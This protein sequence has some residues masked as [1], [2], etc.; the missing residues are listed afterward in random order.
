MEGTADKGSQG[1][2][3]PVLGAA[4]VLCGALGVWLLAVLADRALRDDLLGQALLVAG[5]VDVGHIRALAGT[6]ADLDSPG[7][8][9]LKEQ[10]AAVR[11]AKPGCRFAYLMARRA[12]GTVVFL[13]DSEPAGSEDE[14]PAGRI[15]WDMP[16]DYLRA[17]DGRRP[18]VAGPVPDRW[19]SWVTALVPLAD[20]ASGEV[21]AVLGMD[22][23]ARDWTWGVAAR[24]ALPT[25]MLLVL[26]GLVF[27]M[28]RR[29]DAAILA[30][31]ESLRKSEERFRLLAQNM[32]GVVY[33]RRDDGRGAM[34]YVNDAVE[35]LTGHPARDFLSGRV[36]L[37]SLRHPADRA[38]IRS[39]ATATL[40][41]GV[42]FRHSYRIAHR[43][44]SWRWIEE[45]AV[46]VRQPDG[47]AL[48][49]GHLLDI[50]DRMRAEEG[51]RRSEELLRDI[52][53]STL[54]GYWE[55][56]F[57]AGTAY[58]SPA[59]KRMFGYGESEIPETLD[60]WEGIVFEDDLPGDHE[61][62]D[63]HVE[64]R[65]GIPYYNE[66]RYRHRDGSLVWVMRT[67][68]V[69]EWA[70]DGSPLRMVGCHV[71]ISARRAAEETAE[72]QRLRLKNI[73]G[74]TGAGTW[75][76]IAPTGQM[77]I[78]ERCAEIFGYSLAEIGP[79]SFDF[80][81]RSINPEDLPQVRERLDAHFEGRSHNC[82]CEY[83]IR[84]KDGRW[85][86]VQDRG[87]VVSR[88]ADGK[89]LTMYG[90]IL[91]ISERKRAEETLREYKA[92][93]EQ[94]VDGIAL[95]DMAGHVRM[96]NEA[97]AEMHGYGREELEGRHLAIFHTREQMAA[98]VAPFIERLVATG[99]N[100]GEL[101]HVRKDGTVF[102]AQ[103]SVTVL[104]DAHGEPSGLLAVARDIT[105][106]R[107]A[108]EVLRES[109]RRLDMFFSQS[110]SGCFFMMLDEPVAWDGAAATEKEALLDY[111]MAH[112]RMT[113]VNQAMLEQYGA[114]EEDFVGLTP[115]DLFAHDPEHG[116]RI[117]RGLFDQG[118]W[119]VETRER[120][121][122]GTP[123]RIEGDYICLYDEQGRIT[124]HFGV[125][126]EI[127]GGEA[128]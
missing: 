7:Y 86:W 128:G 13:A 46:P 126:T 54:L 21:P 20:P 49:E 15:Y 121:L 99:S 9:R 110:L 10:L 23:A 81:E 48:V 101:G 112:Q 42:P 5:A 125:Q 64:S 96:V 11:A 43:D 53:E 106:S 91:E 52:L 47:A 68:R 75:E 1:I 44:G 35:E 88:D 31:Q 41:R 95:A 109:E 70:G 82:V 76:W 66:L 115:N 33:L 74:A 114:S 36:D 120:R 39:L 18:L 107:R 3:R 108:E 24:A 123:I 79:L 62:L 71:D 73:I 37:A 26:L 30:Q 89:P 61:L 17:F 100:K 98:E 16:A 4:L 12:D 118:R 93:V 119:H 80:W 50:T 122:D 29:S 90:T 14:S 22:I 40:V 113:R 97:W 84:H 78:D 103:M 51:K 94:S 92:A 67:G 32:P 77:E 34:L 111:V 105:E 104:R 27:A 65:G 56:D 83:R 25:G 6:E 69:V 28:L 63:R 2:R 60:A 45:T 72:K 87:R 57:A 102:P 117:W 58:Y 116:R 8:L 38:E 85:I 19:G 55:L 124:G 59:S 127:A